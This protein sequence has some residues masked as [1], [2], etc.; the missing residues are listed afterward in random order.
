MGEVKLMVEGTVLERDLSKVVEEV[1]GKWR[2]PESIPEQPFFPM[3][4]VWL[5]LR[6]DVVRRSKKRS[7]MKYLYRLRPYRQRSSSTPGNFG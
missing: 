3:D 2:T 5:S 7:W 4:Q 1:V 6:F